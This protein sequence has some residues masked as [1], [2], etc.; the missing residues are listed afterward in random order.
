MKILSK[1]PENPYPKISPMYMAWELAMRE[2]VDVDLDEMVDRWLGIEGREYIVN[3]EGV[4]IKWDKLFTEFLKE[5]LEEKHE[6][7]QSK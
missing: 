5:Q 4:F 1:E 7:N 6:T 2:L 3:E